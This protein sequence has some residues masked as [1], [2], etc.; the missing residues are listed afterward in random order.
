[1]PHLPVLLLS[2]KDNEKAKPPEKMA[3]AAAGLLDGARCVY[4]GFE[5][6][7]CLRRDF[8]PSDSPLTPPQPAKVICSDFKGKRKKG[9]HKMASSHPCS[10]AHQEEAGPQG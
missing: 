10:P 4:S 2:C 1:M 9:V 7:A 3:A 8:D 5:A 6:S